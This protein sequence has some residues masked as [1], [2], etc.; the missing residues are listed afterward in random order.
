M[1]NL[2]NAIRKEFF[3]VLVCGNE[4]GKCFVPGTEGCSQDGKSC[5][6]LSNYQGDLCQECRNGYFGA[7][8]QSK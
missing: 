2:C 1:L 3:L 8:C 7:D 6:C 4:N 5:N